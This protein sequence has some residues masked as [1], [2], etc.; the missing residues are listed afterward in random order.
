MKPESV[1]LRLKNGG[2]DK[3]YNA[4]LVEGEN[5][6][7]LVNFSYGKYGSSLRTGTKTKSP[8]PYDKAKKVYDDLVQSKTSK[9][10]TPDGSGIA[11]TG[12]ENAGRVTGY[13]PQLLNTASQEDIKALVAGA[14]GAWVAQEKHDGERR[15]L[16]VE[17]GKIVA[18]NRKGL[19]VPVRT[20]FEDAVAKIVAHGLSDFEL[21][22]EDM[23]GSLVP[24]DILSIE[25]QDLRKEPFK[26]RL[27]KLY[28][29]ICLAKKAEVDHIFRE[30]PSHIMESPEQVD[31]MVDRFRK[32]KAEGLVF[33]LL[34]APYEPGKPNSG[35]SQLKLKFTND[36]T[37]RVAGHVE[38]K[39]SVQMEILEDGKWVNVGKVTIPS[40]FCLPAVGALID[41]EYL[42]AYKGGALF[43]PVYRAER[44]DY[45]AEECTADKLVY[46]RETA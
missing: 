16:K 46:K 23:G 9:G 20:E 1:S 6:T 21:D 10:Y 13:L 42:Y 37:V 26:T 14:P 25:G 40:S 18:S 22:C 27:E 11:F 5:G 39:S 45:D 12:T 7:W 24:F 28:T 8:L 36:I 38:G 17:G 3:A 34:T 32:M 4:E 30:T 2:S 41:V 15:G 35:G 31:E 33:K 44:T 43:Q 29:F 19:E